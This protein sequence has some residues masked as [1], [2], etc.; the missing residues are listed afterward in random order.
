M[1]LLQ[2]VSNL[3]NNDVICKTCSTQGE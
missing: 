3:V 2:R 1:T